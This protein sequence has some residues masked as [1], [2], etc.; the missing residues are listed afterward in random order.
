MDSTVL[1]HGVPQKI[2]KPTFLCYILVQG[3]TLFPDQQ[4]II[5]F[6][7]SPYVKRDMKVVQDR[8]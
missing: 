1:W 8:F 6:Q 2:N 4:I 3:I 5:R 7:Q